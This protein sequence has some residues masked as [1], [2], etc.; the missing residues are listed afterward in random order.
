MEIVYQ[1]GVRPG[2]VSSSHR[3]STRSSKQCTSCMVA[4]SVEEFFDGV[5]GVTTRT[6]GGNCEHDSYDL[7]VGL[8]AFARH[9]K[10]GLRDDSMCTED[11]HARVSSVDGMCVEDA[12]LKGVYVG[13]Q[14][15]IGAPI[16]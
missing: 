12:H 2:V 13:L 5:G 10:K 16:F 14:A 15:G 1:R 8:Q 11:S 6:N 3:D 7:C 9:V 4:S